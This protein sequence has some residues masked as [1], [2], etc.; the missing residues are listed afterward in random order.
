MK[1][2]IVG[3]MLVVAGVQAA[4]PQLVEEMARVEGYRP[5]PYEDCGQFSVGYG[6]D[7][8]WMVAHGYPIRHVSRAVATKALDERLDEELAA[9]SKTFPGF[10][11]LPAGVQQAL[12]SARYNCPALIGPILRG[13][14]RARD[15]ERA[16][17][18]L[19]YGHDPKGKLGLVR[20][21]FAEA[22]LI[23]ADHGLATL[24]AP[25]NMVQF[26]YTKALWQAGK[27]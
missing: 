7:T 14:V 21:R 22:N 26:E 15:W 12:C 20:R 2:Y 5:E 17:L 10:E 8:R 13:H 16:S 9:L 6:L 24:V 3:L 18:E 11:A 1:M 19:A 4:P 23:R 25:K 27:L